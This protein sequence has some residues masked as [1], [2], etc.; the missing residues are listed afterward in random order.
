MSKKEAI[1]QNLK[2]LS[3]KIQQE[4]DAIDYV[5][6]MKKLVE[7][8]PDQ[9]WECVDRAKKAYSS[10]PN[11]D[12]YVMSVL[13]AQPYN[14]KLWNQKFIHTLDCPR[15]YLNFTVFKYYRK[16]DELEH[17]WTL[18]DQ[19]TLNFYYD[20]RH[21]ASPN[22]WAM[23]KDIIAYK[24]GSLYKKMQELNGETP[25]KPSLIVHDYA[26]FQAQS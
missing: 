4:Q 24:D 15:P 13:T 1:Q 23:L 25:E 14:R 17:I 9:I 3:H 5:E 21:L 8:Y 10:N 2:Q 6:L 7:T 18:P 19:E 16:S 26:S 12:F 20:N 22:D 11:R